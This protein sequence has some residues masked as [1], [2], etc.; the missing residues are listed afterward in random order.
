MNMR[1]AGWVCNDSIRNKWT[2][3]IIRRIAPKVL[4]DLVQM[5]SVAHLEAR[6]P[7]SIKH[8]LH[9]PTTFLN[10][11]ASDGP[12]VGKQPGVLDHKRHQL[13]RIAADIE[14]LK[15]GVEDEVSK[16][17]VRRKSDP[18]PMRLEFLS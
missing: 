17:Q 10:R 11:T 6:S 9:L 5:C 1:K 3:T 12:Y 4:L 7:T 18:M 14:K 15:V 13:S 16:G 8:L 2:P